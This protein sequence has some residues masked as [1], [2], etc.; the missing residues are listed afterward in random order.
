MVRI[1]AK[2]LQII[3]EHPIIICTYLYDIKSYE[4]KA[5]ITSFLTVIYKHKPQNELVASPRCLL[6]NHFACG[7]TIHFPI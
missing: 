4:I 5:L 7:F 2:V 3:S 1:C 6:P